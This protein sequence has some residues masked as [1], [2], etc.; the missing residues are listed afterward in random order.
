M[1][2]LESGFIREKKNQALVLH[3]GTINNKSHIRNV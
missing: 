3:S 2:K 1:Q